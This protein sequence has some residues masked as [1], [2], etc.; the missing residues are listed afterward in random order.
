MRKCVTIL[1][2]MVLF[3]GCA[4]EDTFETVADELLPPAA[5]AMAKVIV[6]LPEEA[7]AP[8][9]QSED[10]TLYQCDGYEILLQ[11]F[12]SGD[13]DATLRS[14]TGY[15]RAD[16]TVMETRAGKIKRYDF[17]WSCLGEN[18]EQ[19]GRAC[20]LD[21]GSYHYVLS[22][23]ADADRAGEFGENWEEIFGA[24]SLG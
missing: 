19:V 6:N 9:S 12:S 23:L 16:L 3:A 11:T 15:G 7:A 4:A 20:V 5:P 14:T 10:G 24:Y 2:M 13:L 8:V 1:M 22:V 17:V 21:D 18:G